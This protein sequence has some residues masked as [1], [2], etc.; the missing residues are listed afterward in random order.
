[1]IGC[2]ASL[3]SL[4]LELIEFR[5]HPGEKSLAI[6]D[7]AFSKGLQSLGDF[8]ADGLA[9]FRGQRYVVI[10]QTEF[11]RVRKLLRGVLLP[12]AV[13]QVA[14]QCLAHDI[15]RR[16]V[17]VL[18]R[19]LDLGCEGGGNGKIRCRC[20]A[21]RGCSFSRMRLSRATCS[22][23]AGAISGSHFGRAAAALTVMGLPRRLSPGS[24][25]PSAH[26]GRNADGRVK[27]GHDG[28]SQAMTVRVGSERQ[29]GRLHHQRQ[30]AHHRQHVLRH[31]ARPPT[32]GRSR[33][34][35]GPARPRW[36]VAMLIPAPA[37]VAPNRPM[38]PGLSWLVTYSMCGAKSASTLMPLISTM[39]GR[40]P[41]EQR[42]GDRTCQPVGR[43]S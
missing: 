17:L 30:R 18:G 41:G 35:P 7:F 8:L 29:R 22:V 10:G 28:E 36:K 14:L 12:A 40:E 23:N 6:G 37:S 1:M 24:S 31:A 3:M 43:R 25:R 32:P 4:P 16:A 13:F 42:A 15:G 27:P 33:R 26:H 2:S 39:R 20:P 11:T 5:V 19:R 21:S 9:V 34:R 38:K